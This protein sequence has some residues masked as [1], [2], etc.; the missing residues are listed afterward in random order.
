VGGLGGNSPASRRVGGPVKFNF[1]GGCAR[2]RKTC[3]IQFHIAGH[4][5]TR[6]AGENPLPFFPKLRYA[7]RMDSQDDLWDPQ[8]H[9]GLRRNIERGVL[10]ET[11]ALF[12]ASYGGV[13][14]E[15]DGWKLGG[16]EHYSLA[17][18]KKAW[19]ERRMLARP[20]K[21]NFRLLDEKTGEL[22]DQKEG[23]TLMRV[24]YYTDRGT[25]VYNGNNYSATSQARL[26]PG[27]YTRRQNNGALET[28]LNVRVG[29]GKAMRVGLDAETGQFRLR[30]S[31]SN[32]HLY[33][34]L[35][36]LG[37]PDSEIEEAWGPEILQA[38]AAK[39][40]SK[41]LERAFKKMVP[42]Y[43]RGDGTPT[44]LLRD[45][46]EKAQVSEKA[47]AK[48]LA[49]YWKTRDK[50]KQG[51]DDEVLWLV[52]KMIR[53]PE[54]R[55]NFNA[56][57]DIREILGDQ[58]TEG[59]R[60]RPVGTD[61]LL[62]STRK[63]LAVNRG[64]DEVD[65]RNIPAF[66]K[67]Y[68]MDKLMR[69]RI[70]FDEGKKRR[71]LLRMV[72]SRKT[73]DPLHPRV[74]DSY[75]QEIITKNPL[76]SPIEETNPLQLIGQQRRVTQMGPGGI[77]SSDAITRDMQAVQAD[78][79]GFYSPVETPES[80]KAGVDVRLAWGVRIGQDGRMRKQL[81]N[82]RTG[83][84]EWVSPEDLYGKFLKLPD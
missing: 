62:A 33:S 70:R 32:L 27:A 39:Y 29:T 69:E 61:G 79:F 7:R 36:D 77:G 54:K 35:K 66:T 3:E 83:K 48:T 76:T 38:N 63:L 16:K 30:T 26:L 51:S 6:E 34:L 52:R 13:R 17:D 53:R 10:E 22:L 41:T 20:L 57:F 14:L 55:S 45:A 81:L 59:D 67:I 1:T 25:F 68:P 23:V 64:Q 43:A 49:A 9:E 71:S 84:N 4:S 18:Q 56:G 5:R 46:L 21:A 19:L 47:V 37:V 31:G 15:A 12:P 82:R 75:L 8:D 2:G 65:D 24:P 80:E 40:D 58:D 28:Q 73:L 72:A 60:Y 44:D 42:E 74:F 11:Q 78:E 50:I